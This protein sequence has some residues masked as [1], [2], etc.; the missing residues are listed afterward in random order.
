[1]TI[2]V[3]MGLNV[4]GREIGEIVGVARGSVVKARFFV[5]DI[6]AS[7]RNIVGGEVNEYS[8]LLEESRSEA[9]ARM[10][11]NAQSMGADAIICFRFSTSAIM[12]GSSEI[13]AYGTAVKLK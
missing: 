13:L 9:Y 7:L 4:P 1:M 12:E 6:F 11:E 8:E 5:R 3:T 10:L 2:P